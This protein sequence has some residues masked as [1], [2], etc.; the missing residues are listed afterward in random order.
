MD[1]KPIKI[2]FPDNVEHE[3]EARQIYAL[4]LAKL[5]D[6]YPSMLEGLEHLGKQRAEKLTGDTL[7]GVAELVSMCTKV[8]G[9]LKPMEFWGN[10]PTGF[11][12]DILSLC[13]PAPDEDA[14]EKKTENPTK[15]A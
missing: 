9:T 11:L 3:I 1:N 2:L 13:F 14:G 8:E 4:E 5:I 6:K 15:P 10:L 12:M 7:R